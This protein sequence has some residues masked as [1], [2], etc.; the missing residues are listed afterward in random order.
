MLL[1]LC[2]LLRLERKLSMHNHL[3][4]IQEKDKARE[5]PVKFPYFV[6]ELTEYIL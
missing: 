4:C 1:E 5:I 6:G 2:K 3:R